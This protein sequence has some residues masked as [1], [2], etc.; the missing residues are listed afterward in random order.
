MNQISENL[1]TVSI[2]NFCRISDIG[3][4]K[5]YELLSTGLSTPSKLA[6]AG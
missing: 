5:T 1:I 3:R 4:S 2:G 6:S